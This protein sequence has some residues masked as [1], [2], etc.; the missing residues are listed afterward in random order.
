M[1]VSSE[2]YDDEMDR[3]A[4]MKYVIDIIKEGNLDGKP[5]NTQEYVRNFLKDLTTGEFNLIQQYDKEGLLS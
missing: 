1:Q 5:K 3:Y 2:D 4:E